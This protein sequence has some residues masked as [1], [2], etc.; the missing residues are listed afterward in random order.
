MAVSPPVPTRL[1]KAG[2]LTV[3]SPSRLSKA[4][5]KATNDRIRKGWLQEKNDKKQWNNNWT[6]SR[7]FNV[8]FVLVFFLPPSKLLVG[9]NTPKPESE[10]S[11]ASDDG[12][13][14]IS[15]RR[16]G[17]LKARNLRVLFDIL[18]SMDIHQLFC[19]FLWV[20]SIPRRW[21]KVVQNGATFWSTCT[22]ANFPSS[23]ELGQG[24]KKLKHVSPL[25]GQAA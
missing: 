2:C 1:N 14:P 18:W 24:G 6:T 23:M 19:V 11:W 9:L 13:I 7:G 12:D 17:I 10:T 15:Q 21:Q 4:A 20:F 3:V 25:H 22:A 16:I 5:F 8:T